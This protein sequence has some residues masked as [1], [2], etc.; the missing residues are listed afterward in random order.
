MKKARFLHA[1][2]YCITISAVH[3]AYRMQRLLGTTKEMARSKKKQKYITANLNRYSLIYYLP[4][5]ITV[6]Q[7]GL[8]LQFCMK[9]NKLTFMT[10]CNRCDPIQA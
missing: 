8:Y 10:G 7:R 4:I 5:I 9:N 1:G 3:Y 2:F 6:Y